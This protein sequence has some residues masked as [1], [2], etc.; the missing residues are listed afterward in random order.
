[1]STRKNQS[2]NKGQEL[3][4]KYMRESGDD[5]TGNLRGNVNWATAEEIKNLK[6][7]TQQDYFDAIHN[8]QTNPVS[9][10]VIVIDEQQKAL[11]LIFRNGLNIRD[12]GNPMFG[13]E[14]RTNKKNLSTNIKRAD[15]EHNKVC[16]IYGGD[17][18]GEEWELKKLNNA[19]IIEQDIMDASYQEVKGLADDILRDE[20][21][22]QKNDTNHI[23]KALFFALGERVKVLKRDILYTLKHPGVEV[24]LVNGAQEEKINKYFK[25]DVL[26]TLRVAINNP[27]LHY[28]RGVNTVVNVEKKNENGH[29]AFATI[30]FLTNNSLS[31][32]RKGQAAINAV[33]LNSGEN[34]A[35]VVFSTNTNV[36]GK[37]GPREYYVSSESTFIETPAKKNP[38]ER[39]R[40]YNTFSLRIP[41]NREITVI[42]GTNV[43][44]AN[45]LEMIVYKEYVK[46][47]VMMETLKRRM[48]ED[49]KVYE[50]PK[51]T[52][53]VRRIQQ[54]LAKREREQKP[55]G[56][57]KN[58][59]GAK[60]GDQMS[61]LSDRR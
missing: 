9:D 40:G 2:E 34:M 37:K 1:M 22:P 38:A 19:K 43:P 12:M 57:V 44:H 10:E 59:G 18:L 53:P 51:T 27:R 61:D 54:Y 31:K 26:E 24:Y 47:E 16:V 29:N 56:A 5:F 52:D 3:L 17:L 4:D 60:N 58:D 46:N 8:R 45:P 7:P 48:T 42:E 30:G 11:N 49:L 14:D 13:E 36:A 32:A 39:P 55:D 33:K 15:A 28:I 41:A 50:L 21:K 25:I 35:D 6:R 23:K 20:E